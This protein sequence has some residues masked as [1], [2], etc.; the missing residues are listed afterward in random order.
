MVTPNV[1]SFQLANNSSDHQEIE[2]QFNVPDLGIVENWI[3]KRKPDPNLT[4]TGGSTI[5]LVDVYF[6]TDDWRFY[7]AGYAL[8]TRRQGKR[9]E[10]TLKALTRAANGAQNRREISQTL[11]DSSPHSLRNAP[12][13]VGR[14]L[15]ALGGPHEL[16][17]IF[18]LHTTR[19][20]YNIRIDGV[21]AGEI[22]LDH[23]NVLTETE[24]E[25]TSLYRIEIEI[26][27]GPLPRIEEFVEEIRTGCDLKRSSL[28]KYEMGL[29]ANGL[30]PI[31]LPDLGPTAIDDSMSIGEV[32][33][34]V[35][36]RNFYDFLAHEPGTRIG[37]DAEELHDMR[38]ASRRLRTAMKLF[39]DFLPAS[40]EGMRRRFGWIA[41][42]LGKVRDLDV[43]LEEV[44]IWMEGTIP[45]D[46]DALQALKGLLQDRRNSARK[47]MFRAL[48][49]RRYENFLASYTKLLR[50]TPPQQAIET[51]L[52]VLAVAPDLIGGCYKRV[53]KAMRGID[54]KSPDEDVH[55]LRIRC[56]RLRYTLEFMEDVYGKRVLRFIRGV[57]KMQDV[58]GL[59]NDSVVA[60]RHLRDLT[61]LRGRRLPAETLFVMGKIAQGYEMEAA[62]SRRRFPDAY[63]KIKKPWQG[64]NKTMENRRS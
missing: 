45:A 44:G 64:L 4:I 49:S 16:Q 21:P 34:A 2:W 5:D 17:G 38:V 39:S 60:I 57:K 55:K 35:L 42:V 59:Y 50:Y 63:K 24:S 1:D 23:T 19:R 12:G 48:D 37:E 46:R 33:F 32:A 3:M 52:P 27:D 11:E 40:A 7:R 47:R 31:G 14:W 6:D 18:E 54:A 15:G 28:S 30:K 25:P 20:T 53:R 61:N 41:D 36:R 56:K 10:A 62:K 29:N 26:K 22:V 8:R 43:Q 9:V 13:Q 51:E 58:L